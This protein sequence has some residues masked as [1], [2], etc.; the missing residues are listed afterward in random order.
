MSDPLTIALVAAFTSAF[1]AS[2]I[3]FVYTWWQR[4]QERKAILL[5]YATEFVEAL[6]R[7]TMYYDQK[8]KSTISISA[9][10]EGTDSNTLTRLIHLVAEPEVISAVFKLKERYF[11]IQRHL[12]EASSMAAEWHLLSETREDFVER[13]E[14]EDERTVEVTDRLREAHKRAFNAQERALVYFKFA[15]MFSWT[16]TIVQYVKKKAKSRQIDELEKMLYEAKRNKLR[17]DL[18]LATGAV[19]DEL[20]FSS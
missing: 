10:Y 2:G 9:I 4:R 20:G 3:L 1:V 19:S 6:F 18:E 8:S 7:T 14:A 13:Y 11:Q 17:A 16:E 12:G 5:T 15:E